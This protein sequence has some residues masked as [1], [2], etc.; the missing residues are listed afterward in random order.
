MEGQINMF[1]LTCYFEKGHFQP[2]MSSSNSQVVATQC[3]WCNTFYKDKISWDPDSRK[4]SF[5]LYAILRDTP[6]VEIIQCL[7]RLAFFD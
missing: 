1:G 7:Q 4:P 6:R 2:H 5:N 3:K